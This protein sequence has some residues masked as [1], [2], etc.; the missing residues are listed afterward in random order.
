MT[1][2]DHLQEETETPAGCA[3]PSE[4]QASS[5]WGGGSKNSH[6]NTNTN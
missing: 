4:K 1:G 3:G 5:N 2:N 6:G